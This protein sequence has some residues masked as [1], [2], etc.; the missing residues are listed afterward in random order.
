MPTPEELLIQAQSLNK[1]KSYKKVI[2]LLTDEVLQQAKSADLY[3]E[4]AQAY[5]RLK[6]YDLSEQV[7]DHALRINPRQAK[8][9]Y[10]KG[11]RLFDLK[12]YNDAIVSYKKA[13]EIDP[14]YA[15]AYN[16]LGNCHY[17]LKKYN[18]AIISYKN[19]I[20]IDH[21]FAL[22]CN[23]LGNAYAQLEK[24]DEAIAAF[25]KAI[26]I[27]SEYTY[28]Y[29]GIGNVYAKLGEYDEAITAYKKTI[30]INP[31]Y[32]S[33]YN[34]LGNVYSH[35]INYNEAIKW[36]TNA[37]AIDPEYQNAY[38]NR[39]LAYYEIKDYANA[40]KD[41]ELYLAITKDGPDDYY[42]RI[43][44]ERVT[45]LKKLL[46]VNLPADEDA[47][48]IVLDIKKLVDNIKALLLYNDGCITHYTSLSVTNKLILE[49]SPFQLSEGAFLNDTS[50]GRELFKFLPPLEMKSK[51]GKGKTDT[52]HIAET[53]K[54]TEARQFAQ[55]P[56]IGSFVS[57]NKHDDLTLWRMYG[58]EEKNEA[59]GCAITI[60]MKKLVANLKE[61]LV[62]D[63]N[64]TPLMDFEEF[65][66][67]RV[68]YRPHNSYEPFIIPGADD[69]KDALNNCMNELK[70]KIT[71]LNKQ[72]NNSGYLQQ[73]QQLLNGIAYLFKTIEYQYEHELRLV[74]NGI[75]FKKE[76]TDAPRVY[77][78]L[79]TIAPA[80]RKITLGPKVE[81]A[82]EHAATF[83]YSLFKDGFIP[84]IFISRLPFK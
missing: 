58:K 64:A 60:D 14:A 38:F 68:A 72:T 52:E 28:A 84:D 25:K 36:H 8:G 69:K 73:V 29:N 10:Y 59:M 76:I 46:K 81:K 66:F 27:D 1:S 34:G 16:G 18:E 51:A 43:A 77:I 45:E 49:Q 79:V 47:D 61:K 17:K 71:S 24:N 9:H 70:G 3:A 80:I 55:R 15:Y 56:F 2:E 63:G 33:P 53:D 35:L 7:A 74:V 62:P 41:Y 26:E 30:E 31:D 6:Q 5:Y 75:G 11:N 83:H 50:E 39:G 23:G 32:A 44:Q 67:Y 42:V 22:P 19:A 78:D 40:L 13:L 57:E 20:E 65:S 82:E 21:D 54:D 4:Q 48:K 37:I 12:E